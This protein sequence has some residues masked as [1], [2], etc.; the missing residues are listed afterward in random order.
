MAA[1]RTQIYLTAEL[2][3]RIDSVAAASGVTMAEVIR[4]ALLAYISDDPDPTAALSAT[5]GVSPAAS[6]P[7]RH[8]WD[9]G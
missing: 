8:E 2:R 3:Q 9:R 4:R 1:I 5:F 6:V 7:S